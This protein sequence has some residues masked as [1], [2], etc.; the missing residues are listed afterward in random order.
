LTLPERQQMIPN[1]KIK[2][3]G[4]LWQLKKNG[5]LLWEENPQ[6]SFRSQEKNRQSNG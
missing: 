3:R 5:W 6:K 2:Q 4:K 1:M